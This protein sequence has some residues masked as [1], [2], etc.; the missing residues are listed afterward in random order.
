MLFDEDA[1]LKDRTD[2]WRTR[3]QDLDRP[4]GR[5]DFETRSACNLKKHGSWRYSKHPTTEAMCLAYKLPGYRKTALWHVAHPQHLIS[6]SEPPEDLF[7]FIQAGGL[8]EAHNAFFERVIWMHV[9][10]AR[11]GW[12]GM[13]HLQWRCSAAKACAAALPRALEKAADA[14][15]L[16]VRKDMDGHK[17][18]LKMSK[19]RKPRKAEVEKWAI[20]HGDNPMPL[21]WHETEEDVVRQWAYCRNDVEVEEA[22]SL[23]IRDLDPGELALWQMDQALNERGTRFDLPLAKAALE[24]AELWK[25]EL[26][27]ELESL[28]GISS[29]TKRARVKAWLQESENVLVP[30]TAADTFEWYLERGGVSGRARRVMEITM[31]VNRTSTR[32]YS[33]MLNNADPDDWRIRDL[34]MF[35]GAG[36]GRWA[37]R[38]VQIHNLPARDLII[39]TDDFDFA[40][41]CVTSRDIDWCRAMYG[42]VMRLLSHLLR[43]TIVSRPGWDLVVADYS[44]IEARG[45]LWLAGAEPALEVFRRGGDIYCDMATGIYGYEVLKGK[46]KKERQFGKQSILGLGYGMGFVTFLLTCRTYGIHFSRA[47]VIRIMGL[48]RLDKYEKWVRNFVFYDRQAS[49]HKTRDAQGKLQAKRV[50]RRLMDARE[51]PEGVIHELALMKHTVDVY[52]NRY[53]QVK[54]MWKD[55]E[56]AAIRAVRSDERV[57]CGRVAWF[58]EN[59]FMYCELPSG[60]LLSYREPEIKEVETSWGEKRDGLRYMH[61]DGTTRQWRRTATYGGKLV[62]NITQAVARDILANAMM[63]ADEHPSYLPVMHVHDELVCEVRENEGSLEEF[64]ELMS[65]VPAWAHGCPIGAE[66]ERY[67]RYR[68]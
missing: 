62:E 64:E 8:V 14:M 23:S 54:Q 12:P 51:D 67:K 17:L 28:T 36:T 65:S 26:N 29:A 44:A 59:D 40:A 30:N 6:E 24:V 25:T 16:P 21:L 5:I 61:V 31:D 47:D 20:D 58:V 52:R 22:L 38:G 50:R 45:V 33:A 10:V 42:D 48:Q 15:R 3:L 39:K 43:G 56:T 66:A 34:L 18:M 49:Q 7:A 53:P 35:C 60:R 55:Q 41:E 32:K 37:S 27:A 4:T 46:H 11:H 57:E 2:W 68:K 63:L 9:M 1:L 13:P 19:P